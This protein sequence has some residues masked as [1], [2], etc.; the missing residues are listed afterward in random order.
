VHPFPA[1]DHDELLTL[2]RQTRAAVHDRDPDRL[3]TDTLRLFQALTV[4]AEDERRAFLAAA[5]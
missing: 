4:Q 2:A 3:E 1:L 5:E